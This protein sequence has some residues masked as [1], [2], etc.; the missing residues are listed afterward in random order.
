MKSSVMKKLS[1]RRE[2]RR[3]RCLVQHLISRNDPFRVVQVKIMT[4]PR[5]HLPKFLFERMCMLTYTNANY[6]F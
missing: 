5:K 2:A 4:I 6:M 1:I 3:K